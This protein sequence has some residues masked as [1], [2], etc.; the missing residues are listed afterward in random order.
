MQY[1]TSPIIGPLETGISL[2]RG[3]PALEP[4]ALSISP[5]VRSAQTGDWGEVRRCQGSEQTD[6]VGSAGAWSLTEG[7]AR[8]S[9]YQDG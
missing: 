6:G 9:H 3:S 2:L 1:G 5:A 7:M 4:M 8:R